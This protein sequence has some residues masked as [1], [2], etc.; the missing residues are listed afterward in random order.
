MM[1]VDIVTFK[2]QRRSR[3]RRLVKRIE[4]TLG[5]GPG[6]TRCGYELACWDYAK[7]SITVGEV[8]PQF[9]RYST[10]VNRLGHRAK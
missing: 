3:E 4:F 5:E 1:G 10:Q 2:T 9:Q 8:Y 7:E 6:G